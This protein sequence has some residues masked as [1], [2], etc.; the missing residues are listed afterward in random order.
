M[1]IP[2]PA[3]PQQESGL[4]PT[5]IDGLKNGLKSCSCGWLSV[6][7]GGLM[8]REKFFYFSDLWNSVDFHGI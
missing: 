4:E 8:L 7:L 5:R 1:L 2:W 6:E 3:R